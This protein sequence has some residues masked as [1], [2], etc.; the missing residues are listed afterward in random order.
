[1]KLKIEN[2]QVILNGRAMSN[3]HNHRIHAYY[4][5]DVDSDL[6]VKYPEYEDGKGMLFQIRMLVRKKRRNCNKQ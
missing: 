5:S 1:M 4:K 3:S 2:N 6:S